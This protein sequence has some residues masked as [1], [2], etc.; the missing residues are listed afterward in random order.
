MHEY[1]SILTTNAVNAKGLLACKDLVACLL[2]IQPRG[3]LKYS[4]I[5]DALVKIAKETAMSVQPQQF[6]GRVADRVMT[7]LAHC[8]RLVRKDRFQQATSSLST[9]QV[10]EL[11]D[12]VDMLEFDRNED[13][14]SGHTDSTPARSLKV[15]PSDVSLASD[16]FPRMLSTPTKSKTT[17][18]ETL[19]AAEA[20][21]E[22]PVPCNKV[23]VK[24]HAQM[25]KEQAKKGRVMKKPS[26][27]VCA[28]AKQAQ[29]KTKKQAKQKTHTKKVKKTAMK[30][31][32]MKKKV[33]KKAVMKKDAASGVN[34]P[35][36][37]K[38]TNKWHTLTYTRGVVRGGGGSYIVW[39]APSGER[40]RTRKEAIARGFVE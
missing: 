26:A 34:A 21:D 8:R 20:M 12:L 24:L 30:T 6:A 27:V 7:L 13:G 23:E 35:V 18:A 36:T 25:V 17:P 39:V 3:S 33:M 38:Y 2:R 16:G 29:E 19:A 4:V 22:S 11:R 14:L 28:M 32:T 10:G 40:L 1:T 37:K 5:K 31:T 15:Q 9:T